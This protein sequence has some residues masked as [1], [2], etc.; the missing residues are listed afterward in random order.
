[1]GCLGTSQKKPRCRSR[2]EGAETVR[3]FTHIALPPLSEKIP[4]G[5]SSAPPERNLPRPALPPP[6]AGSIRDPVATRRKSA[7]S[8]TVLL[9]SIPGC[10]AGAARRSARTPWMEIL[11]SSHPP[12]VS[13][14][15]PGP[16]PISSAPSFAAVEARP[17]RVMD[18]PR[19]LLH[20]CSGAAT[21]RRSSPT[22]RVH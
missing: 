7:F 3:Q 11:P 17:G 1:M 21:P 6:D 20:I 19:S 4:G 14:R 12:E 15:V 8:P 10:A 9:R 16:T 2:P 22:R 18:P 13:P 5:G